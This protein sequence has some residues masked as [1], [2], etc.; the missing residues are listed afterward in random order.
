MKTC[1]LIIFMLYIT[2]SILAQE[3]DTTSH[4]QQLEEKYQRL[5]DSTSRLSPFIPAVSSVLIN[6]KQVELNFFASMISAN[7]YRDDDGHLGDL[8]ARQTYLYRTI[9]ATYGVSKHAR[10]NAGIDVNIVMGRIDQDRTSSMFKVFDSGVEGNSRFARA[11]TSI[12]A[13][14]RWRP[15]RRNYNFTIQS[16]VIFPTGIDR[17]KQYVLGYNQIFLM[18][19]FLYNQPLSE[20]LFLFSQ[21]GLQY[22]FERENVPAA[23]YSPLS[24]YLSY[25]IPRKTIPFILFNYI[26]MFSKN[27]SW[28]YSRYTMQVGGGVQYQITRRLLINGYYANDIKGKNYPDFNTYSLSLRYVLH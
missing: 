22:G 5:K 16:S 23:F 14:I 6:Y 26:P 24:L 9:Q 2:H 10:F 11:I 19:Q 8:N 21:L 3:K 20:R 15:L 28:S 12:A 4:Y 25:L 13:R 1:I 27:N 7:N 17:E 18:S